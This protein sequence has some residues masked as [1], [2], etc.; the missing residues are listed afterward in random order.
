MLMA[1]SDRLNAA[2]SAVMVVPILAPIIKGNEVV[3]DT[4]PEATSGTIREVV[5][6]LDCTPAV[7]SVPQP[8]DL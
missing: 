2:K 7:T 3:R 6:E 1:A 8:K 5:M 4:R